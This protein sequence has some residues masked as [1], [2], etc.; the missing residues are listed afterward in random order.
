M[1]GFG[2]IGSFSNMGGF[3]SEFSSFSNMGGVGGGTSKS[4][5]TST[6]IKL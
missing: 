6:I 3:Q 1:P 5:S 2:N 4:V